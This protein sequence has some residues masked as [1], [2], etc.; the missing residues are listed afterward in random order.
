LNGP[1]NIRFS[2]IIGLVSTEDRRR[3]HEC[4]SALRGQRGNHACEVIVADRRNDEISQEIAR[5]FPEVTLIPCNPSTT[6]PELRTIAL[7]HA[8]GEF[9][10]VTEDHCIP[11]LNWLSGVAKTFASAPASTVAAGGCIENGL[12]STAWDWATYLCEYSGFAEPI[13]EGNTETLPGGNIAYQR[14]VLAN[15]E[16]EVLTSGFWETT[17]HPRLLCQSHTF[18][19]SNDILV[20]H[21]KSFS[22]RLFIAQRFSYSRY[23]AGLR[24]SSHG[25]AW[26]AAAAFASIAV[27]PLAFSRIT[28]NSLRRRRLRSKL[29][30]STPWLLLFTLV[31]GLGE[32]WGYLRGPGQALAEIE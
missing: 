21:R 17:L 8:Q 1:A 6:L 9:I 23:Y 14:S 27:P 31:W 3:I 2:V 10:L 4:L 19:S 15:V 12:T 26:R 18:F 22:F 16:R 5:A 11:D 24:S 32:A 20:N 30:L 7:H 29:L 13:L 28:L 25:W